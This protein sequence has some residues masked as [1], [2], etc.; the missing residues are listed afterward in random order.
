MGS[1]LCPLLLSH[2]YLFFIYFEVLGI[3]TRAWYAFLLLMFTIHCPTGLH[4]QNPSSKTQLLG[5]SREGQQSISCPLGPRS[6][7]WVAC[8]AQDGSNS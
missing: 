8:S 5:M 6:Y 3:E 7:P 1:L 4:F 2:V